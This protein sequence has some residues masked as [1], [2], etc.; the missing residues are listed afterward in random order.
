M[1]PNLLLPLITLAAAAVPAGAVTVLHNWTFNEALGTSIT[2]TANSG[3][4]AASG[5]WDGANGNIATTPGVQTN[6]NGQLVFSNAAGNSNVWLS[7]TNL[8]YGAQTGGTPGIYRVETLITSWDLTSLASDSSGLFIGFVSGNNNTT[9]TVDL[10]LTRN[11]SGNT[12]LGARIGGTTLT[13]AQT[14]TGLT[15]SSLLLRLEVDATTTN[16]TVSLLYNLNDSG[17]V[18]G[19]TSATFADQARNM[20]DFRVRQSGDL[21]GGNISLDYLTISLVPEPSSAAVLVGLAS[22]GALLRRRTRSF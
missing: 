9:V 4:Q 15:G 8:A 18:T 2:A 21:T 14:F 3:T 1:K 17:W 12:V 7:S 6:G 11:A 5:L 22:L 16:K 20:V 13:T 19:I 10:N